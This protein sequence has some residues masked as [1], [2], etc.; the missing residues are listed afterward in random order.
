MATFGSSWQC[1]HA[2]S[3]YLLRKLSFAWARA[4]TPWKPAII[5]IN[6]ATQTPTKY[7]QQELRQSAPEECT[8][9]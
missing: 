6:T 1:A 7:L 5:R 8:A 4:V 3:V 2:P 9:S